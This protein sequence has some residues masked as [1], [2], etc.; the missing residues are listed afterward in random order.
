MNNVTV[1]QTA[2][3]GW[4]LLR[5]SPVLALL[6]VAQ[7]GLGI[8]PGAKVPLLLQGLFRYLQQEAPPA[9]QEHGI[10]I[11]KLMAMQCAKFRASNGWATV[12]LCQRQ[13]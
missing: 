12:S 1:Q 9:L 13:C 6:R 4:C 11:G 10:A 2:Q 3:V 8:C 5:F 7:G